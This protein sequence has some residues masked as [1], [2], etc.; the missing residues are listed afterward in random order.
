MYQGENDPGDRSEVLLNDGTG[1]FEL[2]D[3]NGLHNA[4]ILDT[5]PPGLI[6]ATGI[7]F[8]DYDYDGIL[9]LYISTWFSDYAANLAGQGQYTFP[10]LLFKGNGDG[11]FTYVSSQ[12]IERFTQ[13]MYGVNV[14]DWNN[15]GW[16]DIIT[17][18][19]CRSAGSLFRN[20][21]DGTF[22]DVA[23]QANYSA[24]FM[25]GD[26]GQNLCQWEAQPADFNNDGYMDLL[27]VSVHGGYN[28]NE[29]RTHI[30][31]NTGEETGYRFE[32]DLDRLE[33]IAPAYTHLGDQGGTWLDIDNNTRKDVLVAQMG[34]ASANPDGQERLYVLKQNEDNYFDDI[35]FD[36]GLG[37]WIKEAHSIEPCDF[38]L[39]GSMDFFVSHQVRDTIEG[40]SGPEYVSYMQIRL[41]RNNIGIE[42]NWTAI[43]LI[44]PADAN[45]SGIGSRIYVHSNGV[46]QIR[47]I[48]AGI[49]HFSGQQSFIRTVGLDDFNR[50]D[51]IVVRWPVKDL[52]TTTIYNPPMNLVIN[53]EED[54]YT[55]YFKAWEEEKP[56]IAFNAPYLDFGTLNVGE[57][58]T[59]TFMLENIGTAP[60]LL[61]DILIENDESGE[62]SA[63]M[64]WYINEELPPGESVDIPITFTP[65]SR[66]E[67][68][69]QITFIT[70][71]Q[72]GERRS[73]DLYGSGF[74]PKPVISVNTDGLFYESVWYDTLGTKQF[75]II[76]TGEL[77]LEV[78]SIST[79]DEENFYINEVFFPFTIASGDS[80]PVEVVFSPK[81]ID[82]YETYIVINSNAY[83]AEE[84]KVGA[85]GICDG[86]L[87][88][89][90]VLRQ[91][92]SFTNVEIGKTAIRE[93]EIFNSGNADLVISE[94]V[95]RDNPE[96][97]TFPGTTFP[98]TI[99]KGDTQ[100]IAMEFAPT[101]EKNYGT[102]L[103]IKSNAQFETSISILGRGIAPSSVE[104][105]IAELNLI[106][107]TLAPNPTGKN[108][109]LMFNVNYDNFLR[110][111]IEIVD[112][113][114]RKL[115]D[116]T[117]GYYAPGTYSRPLDLNE[118][119]IGTY[120]VIINTEL[121]R[122]SQKLIKYE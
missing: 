28:N 26:N 89:V 87:P 57:E 76:N 120:F 1:R 3:N 115:I 91:L 63:P 40:E 29:G 83:Q 46:Q 19:Y 38:D 118:L 100:K 80:V 107:M 64:D 86:P 70:D 45:Q 82:T 105:A 67:F 92:I 25:Q 73:F 36:V 98:Y 52:R 109:E 12:E 48:Q 74:E 84:F 90:V 15:D 93:L 68:R 23:P 4:V 22:T 81:A 77:P 75:H 95:F 104:D 2:L 72:N 97:F 102:T 56:V 14:T 66:N 30:A 121:G 42:N 96:N 6:N 88:V 20:N 69:S 10:D 55:D 113:S 116:I 108:T 31:V 101:E 60:L 78:Y 110:L 37:Q 94:L 47:E 32:R 34:Y 7:A 49:G 9:D 27:Q 53:I 5:L 11:S 59:K 58:E 50:I 43:K 35:S 65:N 71:A 114:G 16:Q 41:I 54:G 62:F 18:P 103:T 13:P 119:A 79:E 99:A 61:K 117:E 8:L 39:N 106:E 85:L 111:S 51:S 44:P 122:F 112:L 24:R 21:K 33:R 17:S